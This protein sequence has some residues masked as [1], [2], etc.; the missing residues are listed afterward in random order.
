LY[1]APDEV[2]PEPSAA[3]VRRGFLEGSNINP[4]A[5][6]T[7]MM[8]GLRAY[9]SFQKAIQSHDEMDQRLIS[10]VAR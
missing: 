3:L 6:M 9:E 10:D 1:K 7:R 5:E 4:V 8:T 2:Q